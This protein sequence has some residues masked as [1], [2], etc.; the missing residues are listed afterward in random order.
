MI[1][2]KT[3]KINKPM[4]VGFCGQIG[5]LYDVILTPIGPDI[6]EHQFV[7]GE[8]GWYGINMWEVLEIL[9]NSC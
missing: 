9:S 8:I 7:N 2:Q 4:P 1:D 5:K 3:Y 6:R